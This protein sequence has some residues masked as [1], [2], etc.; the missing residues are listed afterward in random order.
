MEPHAEL[1]KAEFAEGS[2]AAFDQRK[3]LGSD[4]RSVGQARGKARGSGTVP[5]RQPSAEGEHTNLRFVEVSVEQGGE[6]L[7]FRCGPVPGTEIESVIGIHAIG[8]GAESTG[9]GDFVEHGEKFVF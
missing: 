5:S 8:D 1:T 7:M 2:F 3:T 9:A 4:F 6:N